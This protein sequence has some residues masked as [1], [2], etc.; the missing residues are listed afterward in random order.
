MSAAW[1]PTNGKCFFGEHPEAGYA[2]KDDSG[3]FQP[4]CFEC[5]KQPYPVP[6]QFQQGA[7][8]AP[9]SEAV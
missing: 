2:R 6:K 8:G 1:T 9:E 3:A 4:A 7:E 5:A